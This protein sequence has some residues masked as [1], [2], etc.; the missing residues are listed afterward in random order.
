M[1][2]VDTTTAELLRQDFDLP[3]GSLTEAELL[4]WLSARVA[5]LLRDRPDYLMS[6]CYTL[7]LDQQAVARALTDRSPAAPPTLLAQL[8]YERQ[9]R[10]ART[11]QRYQPPTLDDQD[12]W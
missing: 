8:L 6:L 12:A 7:D 10:R 4:H 9:C 2:T 3:R 5:E 11:K 1:P